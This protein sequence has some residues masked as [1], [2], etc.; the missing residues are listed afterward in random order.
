MQSQVLMTLLDMPF[1]D[2]LG[3][4]T[5][6]YPPFLLLLLSSA[7]AFN[8]DRSKFLLLDKEFKRICSQ[9]S[10]A[11]VLLEVMGYL[12]FTTQSKILTSQGRNGFCKTFLE[13]QKCW[14][15]AFSPFP[16]CL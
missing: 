2:I 10:A 5:Y 7:N 15:P 8:L 13:K 6:W 14:S 11:N 12:P 3:K 16:Q 4:R 9:L 1:K